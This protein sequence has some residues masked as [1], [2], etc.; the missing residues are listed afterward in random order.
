MA[1]TE[2][3][4]TT[5]L[6]DCEQSFGIMD[7][8]ETNVNPE[9]EEKFTVQNPVPMSLDTAKFEQIVVE[10]VMQYNL[11]LT[12]TDSPHRFVISVPSA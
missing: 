8:I 9:D 3:S 11:Q 6:S 4:Q 2:I 10:R 5:R 1:N 12:K 7:Y